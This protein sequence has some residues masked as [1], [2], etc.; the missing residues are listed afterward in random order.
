[1][2]KRK[3]RKMRFIKLLFVVDYNDVCSC[4][5]LSLLRIPARSDK[6]NPKKNKQN[7]RA[8]QIT[9]RKNF[10]SIQIKKKGGRTARLESAVCGIFMSSS[11]FGPS[12]R[13]FSSFF[14]SLRIRTHRTIQRRSDFS[15]EMT[16]VARAHHGSG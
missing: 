2:Y 16:P 10:R 13:F 6:L 15:R 9:K 11:L 8:T 3:F 4:S 7:E 14:F 12:S 1:M 5:K